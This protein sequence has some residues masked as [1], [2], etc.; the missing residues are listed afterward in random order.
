MISFQ[1]FNYNTVIN[2]Y[3][4]Q[5]NQMIYERGNIEQKLIKNILIRP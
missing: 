1:N 2:M 5:Q 3:V 4:I